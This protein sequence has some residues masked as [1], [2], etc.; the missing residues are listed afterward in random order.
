M[1]DCVLLTPGAS[2]PALTSVYW[3]CLIVG[4]GLLIV[5][6]LTGGDADAGLDADLDADV[7]LEG[8]VDTGHGPASSLASWISMQFVVFSWPCSA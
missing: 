2:L 4:G 3:I 8:D 6:T 5:S 7:S 1:Y